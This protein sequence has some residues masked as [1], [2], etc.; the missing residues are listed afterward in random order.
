[1]HLGH[2]LRQFIYSIDFISERICGKYSVRVDTNWTIPNSQSN[3]P[4]DSS[5][6]RH[7]WTYLRHYS[8][9]TPPTR[10]KVKSWPKQVH[11]RMLINVCH[12]FQRVCLCL[13]TDDN[14]LYICTQFVFI[15]I[16]PLFWCLLVKYWRIIFRQYIGKLQYLSLQY[17]RR[18]RPRPPN[19]DN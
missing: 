14:I 17:V 6:Y 8:T 15:K 5:E 13:W 18:L 9:T 16:S 4:I 11:S 12:H 1:M 2:C 10:L 7:N 19:C 3:K